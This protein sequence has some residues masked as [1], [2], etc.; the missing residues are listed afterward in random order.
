TPPRTGRTVRDSA[1]A[2]PCVRRRDQGRGSAEPAGQ[3]ARSD[4]RPCPLAFP[5]ATRP[6][7]DT[8]E[9]PGASVG[10]MRVCSPHCGLDPET[11]SGGETYEREL[12][13]HLAGQGVT[14]DLI[15]ARHKRGPEGLAHWG[16]HRLRMGSG[17]GRPVA[18]VVL[19]PGLRRVF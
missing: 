13:R 2:G 15:L 6:A 16:I 17:R 10:G 14:L 12:L 8:H 4:E 1:T 9:A 7:G 18:A 3:P 19:R 11:S 5:G